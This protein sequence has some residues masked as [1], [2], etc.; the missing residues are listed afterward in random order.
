MTAKRASLSDRKPKQGQE[1]GRGADALFEGPPRIRRSQEVQETPEP[2]AAKTADAKRA[3][4]TSTFN[5]YVRHQ[6]FLEEF[7]REGKQE[8]R[9]RDV[10]VGAINK[11]AV[12]QEM[13]EILEA[14]K[15]LQRKVMHNLESR[16]KV[17]GSRHDPGRSKS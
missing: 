3:T 7:V 1:K 15:V 8:F 17:E 5:L 13:L 16:E 2:E 10:G 11:S 9:R 12:L 14:D 4:Q 6:S